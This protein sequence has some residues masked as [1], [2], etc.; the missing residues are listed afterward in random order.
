MMRKKLLLV[1]V[2]LSMLLLVT[3]LPI[4]SNAADTSANYYVEGYVADTGRMPMEGVT[5]TIT[6]GQDPAPNSI[7]DPNGFFSVG[8]S[9]IANLTISFTIYGY[10]VITCPNTS[11]QQG[12]DPLL[13]NLS[14]A[15]Y[16]AATHTYTITGSVADMQCAI[17]GA[18]R[19]VVEGYVSSGSDPVKSATVTLSPVD[20]VPGSSSFSANT[21]SGGYYEVTCPTGTYTL[22]VSGQGFDQ[23][24]PVTV[25]VTGNPSTVNVTIVK[26]ELKK[27]L[28]LDA[29]HIL[30]LVG[31]IVGI[32]MALAAWFLS[33]RLNRPHGVE[34]IDDSAEEED[35]L[36]RL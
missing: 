16:N 31:V 14:K 34:I 30:M 9:S 17:M 35:D 3:L 25:K 10:S 27:Y 20:R 28:G 4:A 1:S 32:L 5:V 7:T 13:L 24:D 21:D 2:A 22:T 8:V 6:D 12:S 23:S 11:I 19:G 26:S 15:A 33:R 18:S 36:R 29:A